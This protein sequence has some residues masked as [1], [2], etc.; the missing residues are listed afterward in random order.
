MKLEEQLIEACKRGNLEE[1]K[2]LVSKGADIHAS[3]DRALCLASHYG[4]LDVL[5]YLQGQK[6]KE[7]LLAVESL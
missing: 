1:V 3:D 7:K 6:F 4:H 2:L 5:S